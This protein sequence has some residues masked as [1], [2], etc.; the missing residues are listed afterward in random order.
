MRTM[1]SLM[2]L[3]LRK[4]IKGGALNILLALESLLSR[5]KLL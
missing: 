3:S 2:F 5:W 4:A 1:E